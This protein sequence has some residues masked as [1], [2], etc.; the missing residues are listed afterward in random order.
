MSWTPRRP[1]VLPGTTLLAH[2]NANRAAPP[3]GKSLSLIPSLIRPRPGAYIEHQ[4]PRSALAE[5]LSGQGRT[6]A[7]RLGKRVGA[8]QQRSAAAAALPE[9]WDDRAGLSSDRRRPPCRWLDRSRFGGHP[10]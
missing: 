10:A 6:P 9:C 3:S 1:S 2:G 4:E 5:R 8:A 7:R